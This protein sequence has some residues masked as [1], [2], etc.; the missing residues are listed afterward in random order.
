MEFIVLDVELL[1]P[2]SGKFALAEVQ[3]I[4]SFDMG[5]NDN[6]YFV[7]SHLGS[8]LK[9]GDTVMGYYLENSNFNS[10][11]FETY[12]ETCAY[13][14]EVI[15]VKKSYQSRRKKIKVRNWKLKSL[16]GKESEIN[17]KR[18]DQA[19]YEEDYER[20][21]QDLEED[22]ELRQNVNLYKTKTNDQKIFMN[23]D[24]ENEI[25]NSDEFPEI[26]VSEL[27]SI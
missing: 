16:L 6:P 2:V 11:I 18:H 12:Q 10:S 13:V 9:A 22:V 3:V 25:E 4:R 24:I 23:V 7:Y 19:F 5:L 20:F 14:P 26:D 1:G 15:L 17:G 27:V 8:I 21:L